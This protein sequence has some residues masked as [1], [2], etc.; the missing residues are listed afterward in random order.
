MWTRQH[1]LQRS[2]CSNRKRFQG[3]KSEMQVPMKTLH[4]SKWTENIKA[5]QVFCDQ[6]FKNLCLGKW[7]YLE[8]IILC[9][10]TQT[11]KDK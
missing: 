4:V 6:R 7:I 10:V 1:G 2:G 9:E 5:D 3:T 11:Q 8:S